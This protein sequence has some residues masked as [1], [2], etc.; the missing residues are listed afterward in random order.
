MPLRG[1]GPTGQRL[2]LKQ[3]SSF[4]DGHELNSF[5]LEDIICVSI[6][7]VYS[8]FSATSIK[9]SRP[10]K[11]FLVRLRREGKIIILV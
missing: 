7:G 3:K 5:S 4:M 2:D 6:R 11:F 9:C 8:P 1:V 10:G